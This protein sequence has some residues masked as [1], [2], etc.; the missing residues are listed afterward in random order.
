MEKEFGG[1]SLGFQKKHMKLNCTDTEVD[2]CVFV[3]AAVWQDKKNMA[4]QDTMARG[5]SSLG[6]TR[7]QGPLPPLVRTLGETV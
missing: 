1:K 7:R 5:R 3:L 4:N 2:L 6:P